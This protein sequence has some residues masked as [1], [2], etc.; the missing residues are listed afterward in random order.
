LLTDGEFGEYCGRLKFSSP[1]V[2]LLK[3]IRTSPPSRRV[4][5]GRESVSGFYSSSKNGFGVQFESHTVEFH[6]VYKL[7]H[8]RD[9]LEYYCQP[10][11]IQLRYLAPSGKLVVVWHTPDYFVLWRDRAGWIE[12]KHKDRL[13]ELTI[14]SPNRYRLVD[15]RWE[16]PAGREYAQPLSL[17][18]EV[19]SSEYIDPT[20]I[21][22]AQFLDDYWRSADPVPPASVEAVLKCLA[23][24]PSITLEGLL[25]E[26]K[27][28]V[29]PDDL[30]Q[31]LAKRA[32][33]FDWS[34]APLV[35]PA[36]VRVFADEQAV[37]QFGAAA[38]RD[39]ISVGLINLRVNGQLDWD[40]KP[41]KILNVGNNNVSLLGEDNQF[42]E[43]PGVV[44]EGLIREGRLHYGSDQ[45]Q[46]ATEHPK[47]QTLL[48]QASPKDLAIANSRAEL[49]Q[50][51]ISG[52]SGQSS[53]SLS[54]SHRRYVS[55]FLQA[56]KIYG[57]GYIGLLP[58]TKHKGNR[59]RRM[60]ELT[61]NALTA[62]IEG[63]Y[64]VLNQPTIYSCWAR[65]KMS[66]EAQSLSYPSYTTYRKQIRE[67]PKYTQTLKRKG[68]RAAYSTS[69]FHWTL[70]RGT[71]RHGDRPF[72]IGH[73]DHTELDIELVSAITGQN[74]RRVWLT[75][76]TDAFSRRVLAFYLT[77]DEPSYRSC[78][79]V[80]RECVRLHQRL[81][82]IMVID[83]GPEFRSTYFDQVIA[84]FEKTKK[85]RPAAKA[86]FGAICE[87]LFGTTNTQFIYNLHG[88]TQITKNVRQVT[89]SNNP[90]NLAV[91]DIESLYERLTAYL[92]EVYDTIEHPALGMSPRD[93][94][95]LGIR[96]SGARLQSIIRY[97][98]DFMMATA[99]STR[100]GTAKVWPGR[101]VTINY[102]LYWSEAFRNPGLEGREV[103][104]R[105]DPWNAAIAWAYANG[106]WVVCHSL[107]HGTLEGRSEK[108]LKIASDLLRDQMRAYGQARL[109]I[110]ASKLAAFVEN[111]KQHE[112][113][114][115]QRARDIESRCVRDQG[116]RIR[117]ASKGSEHGQIKTL[118]SHNESVPTTTHPPKTKRKIVIFGDL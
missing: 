81:P 2:E 24:T 56:Q 51:Y 38:N 20:F 84:R 64:Q 18:Y 61:R 72:E 3:Q 110:T 19:H 59:T 47:V 80:L 99:P 25:S 109:S 73:I 42:T 86:R 95:C 97:D 101:G 4:G 27:D 21:R 48:S 44:V 111:T 79:M 89:K 12:A 6:L 117:D 28:T 16:C 69:E 75:L 71:P 118:G 43:L 9:V 15:N 46:I 7:E 33:H 113:L 34:A 55:Q 23:R 22:N 45:D 63:E 26:I 37:A 92:Y 54:R 116:Y 35:E 98:Q 30:Y 5:G 67:Q 105:Y 96:N 93:A 41:W 50:C 62:S 74:R 65:L 31:L 87:R 58:Q 108:E 11:A 114:L 40:G 49:V 104:V 13:P 82:Q 103:P 100:K 85:T 90:Q 52:D 77:F 66:R 107:H 60:D 8:D 1:T 88:N 53:H 76:L 78:M 10:P 68:R 91:W 57:N 70:E 39:R 115:M 32:I 36:R 94:F 83:G 29:P 14:G 112:S 17:C 106:Q 102:F